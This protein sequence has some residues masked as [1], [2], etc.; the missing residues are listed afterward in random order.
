MLSTLGEVRGC[1]YF[2]WR[3]FHRSIAN[4]SGA[5]DRFFV[6]GYERWLLYRR[7]LFS[8]CPL[9]A[10]QLR[11]GLFDSWEID[12]PPTRTHSSMNLPRGFEW[13]I[14]R[15][16]HHIHTGDIFL[17]IIIRLGTKW[18]MQWEI[19]R[20]IPSASWLRPLIFIP[21]QLWL[22]GILLQMWEKM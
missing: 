21:L 7:Y 16:A 4:Q 19:D 8:N 10:I 11:Y 1:S 18:M 20:G 6:R 5:S 17:A 2:I 15:A 13:L 9:S 3:C 22:H 14:D 12:H